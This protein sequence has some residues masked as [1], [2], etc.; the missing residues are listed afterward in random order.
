MQER[1]LESNKI[2]VV[3]PCRAG[4]YPKTTLYS[5]SK[6]TIDPKDFTVTIIFDE[7]QRGANW[8]RNKG[9]E[10]VLTEFVLFSDDDIEWKPYA[11]ELLRDTLVA[12]PEASYSYGAYRMNGGVYCRKAFNAAA[13]KR[14]NY[15]ST[16]SLIRTE[17]F[18][19]F[20]ESLKRLQ[21]WDLWLTML[22]QYGRVGIYCKS[23]IYDT[24]LDP[25]GISGVRSVI[26]YKEAKSI[27]CTKHNI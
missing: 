25:Y 21:D 27:V 17:H 15:I 23:V 3:I 19:G 26:N 11:L 22:L 8:A 14:N 1:Q 4:S 10:S 6:Q 18:P 13:L 20:D 5:L 7:H 9:F 16:M 12:F 2:S 24:V